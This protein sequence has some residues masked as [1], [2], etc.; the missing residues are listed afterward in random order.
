MEKSNTGH[1]DS[2]YIQN[3]STSIVIE[4]ARRYGLTSAETRE[5]FLKI[6]ETIAGEGHEDFHQIATDVY[7]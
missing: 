6:I 1:K 4:V 2:L 5:L 3:S 7:I